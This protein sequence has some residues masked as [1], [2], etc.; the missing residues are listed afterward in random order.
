MNFKV[1]FRAAL[2]VLIAFPTCLFSQ[3][4]PLDF[5]TL[6][7]E[8]GLPQNSV[9]ALLQDRKGF[10]WVGTQDGLARYDGYEFKVYR[11]E[12]NNPNSLSH[13]FVWDITEDAD[14][15][16]WITTLGNGLT[17]FDPTTEEFT[18]YLYDDTSN[19]GLSHWNTFSTLK[20]DSILLIGTNESLDILNLETQKIRTLYPGL[21]L[22]E[23]SLTSLIRAMVSLPGS[24][25]VWL[26]TTLGLTRLD[27]RTDSFEY[28]R[29]S[30]FG[31]QV[32]LRH[33]RTME[34]F[35]SN[36]FIAT[37]THILKVNLEAGIDTILYTS[38]EIESDR[39]LRFHGFH[40][41]EYGYD[42]LWSNYGFLW[43]NR[44]RKSFEHFNYH[45]DHPGSLSHDYVI[46]FLEA[47]DGTIWAGTRNGLSTIRYYDAGF[48]R[49]GKS[50]NSQFSLKGKGVKSFVDKDSLI[51]IAT[52]EG[53][54]ILN[55][56]TG[57]FH[58][59]H[60]FSEDRIP[61]NSNY[62]LCMI[63]DE[64]GIVWAGSRGGGLI[65]IEESSNG[66]YAIHSG[67]LN[68][69]SI[70]YILDDDSLLWLGSSGHG[71]L[72]YSKREGLLKN[73]P[74]TGN[75]DGPSHPYVY[76]LLS[77]T[78]ENFWLGTPTG[79]L[80]LFHP[81]SGRFNHLT[82]ALSGDS[83]LS[84]NTILAI[85]QDDDHQIW[86]GTTT[87]LSKLLT[88]V[89]PNLFE[90]IHDG[91]VMLSF[92]HYGRE[93]GFPNEVIYGFVE[94]D[95]GMLWIGTNEGLVQFDPRLER[96][97]R[98]FTK[99]EGA[100]TTEY[101]QNAFLK[102]NDSA[103]AYGGVSG[104]QIFDPSELKK[105]DIPPRTVLTEVVVN[106]E[107]V[108]PNQ[109]PGRL[110][111][112]QNDFNFEFAA[113]S[114]VNSPAN[115]YR[116]RLK[117][118]DEDWI[119]RES[120]RRVT[121]TNLDPGSYQFEVISANSDGVWNEAALIVPFTIAP[122]P[123]F[124][125]YAYVFYALILGL[126]VYTLVQIRANQVRKV[127]QRK[128]ELEAARHE[129]R[130]LFRKRSARDFHDEAGNKITRINLL[131]ELA[132]AQAGVD[133]NLKNYLTKIAGNTT[134]LSR[135]M[136][137]FNWALDPDKDSL[138]DLVERIKLFGESMYEGEEASFELDGMD[139]SWHL[140]KLSM[141]VR[142]DVL[143]IFK[144]AINNAAKYSGSRRGKLSVVLEGGSPVFLF[145]DYGK[146]FEAEKNH[147]GYG[148]K[149]MATRAAKHNMDFQII[150]KPELG[151]CV[152]L[153]LPHMGEGGPDAFH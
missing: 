63:E 38:S 125:W 83:A 61:P 53:V 119:Q 2:V 82:E 30:P 37:S 51:W 129:E 102:L 123:W 94:D 85:F 40:R 147:H 122:P 16:L 73:H 141:A 87:G 24:E 69:L 149:N 137:D 46:D 59:I 121:Y 150:C 153:K 32:D 3:G 47:D 66:Q 14:G 71:L 91:S 138:F 134:E 86:I 98:T 97:L 9:T 112:S 43:V 12:R 115:K 70:Q 118:F 75:N 92:K 64:E 27:L 104:F 111:H 136:R 18:Q 96:V 140:Y 99:R 22:G 45:A 74:H 7:V 90:K 42:F 54:E 101:N 144:E 19:G 100:Q 67:I 5:E 76:Y 133:E 81:D 106:N 152:E 57:E 1:F 88:P 131:V 58:H 78:E 110:K 11:H 117:G 79:G 126:L 50:E 103:I 146:G 52:S 36:L 48:E 33:I 148:L 44:A 120:N 80:N 4:L 124:T 23:D 26:S 84:G 8:D 39:T 6:T 15:I 95:E 17:R 139:S 41:G 20:K 109:F 60:D 108:L 29:K 151:T 127:E 34:I 77:D 10:I 49:Y 113:L 132:K 35:D 128:L 31:S 116:Y 65:R 13:N 25:Y 21:E 145:C 56:K 72:K 130:E 142:R 62:L 105:F 68:G 143:M 93:H 135:G 107:K 89:E 114:F 55:R 28:F